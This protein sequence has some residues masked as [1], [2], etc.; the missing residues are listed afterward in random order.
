[1][2]AVG[3]AALAFLSL[4]QGQQIHR[5]GFEGR[6]TAWI[7]GTA[8]VAFRELVHDVT[9]TTARTGQRS[10]HL[11]VT[12]EQSG[13]IYYYYP[14]SRAP[15]TDDLSIS[16][17]IKADRP[18]IQL[19]ARVV[20]PH[21]RN[22]S[23][24]QEPLT[25][26]IYGE[27]LYQNTG[28]WQHL[29]LR[30]PSKLAAQQQRIMRNELKRDVDF[31]DAHVDRVVLNVCAG[32]G[33][34]EL[35]ID[36]L[37]IGPVV[38]ANSSHLTSQTTGGVKLQAPSDLPRASN[39]TG[40]VEV[41]RGQLLVNRKR[42]FIR[43]IRHTDTPLKA[44][45]DAGFN[46]LWFD[47]SVS[48]ATLDEAINLGFWLVPT[49]P[50]TATD[51]RLITADSMR[52]E[53]AR[54][55]EKD[56]VLFWDLGGGLTDEQA[57]QVAQAGQLVR[58]VDTQRP[59]GGDVWDGF[60]PYSLNLDLV[61]MHRWPL[62][63]GLELPQYR[64]WLNQRRLLARSGAFMWTW[65]QTHLPDWYTALVYQRPASAG[66]DEPI[67]P[68]PE[69]I[70]LLTYVALAA[71]CRG[72]G[73]WSDRF[74]ADTHQGRDRLLTLA[75]LNQE[76]KMIEPL[77]MGALEPTW[78]DTSVG[79]VKAAVFRS[80][81]G[82]L[83]MPMWLG[84]GAQY[85]PGQSANVNLSITVPQVPGTAQAFEISPASVRSLRTYREVGG[86]RITLPEFGLTA[87]IVFTADNGQDG[88]LVHFQN[89]VRQT[90]RIAAQWAIY[91]AEEEVDKVSRVEEQLEKAGHTLPDGQKL[92]ENARIRLVSCNDSWNRGDYREAYAEAGR[93]LRP[94]RILMRAQWEQATNELSAPVASP[95]AVSFYT[96]PRHWEFAQ[97]VKKGRI[98]TNVLPGGD[99][100]ATPSPTA[101]TWLTQETT[102][103][104]V[105][106]LASRVTE[107]PREGRQCMM[108]QIDR[109]DKLALPPAALERTFLAVNSPAV[110]LKPGSLVR[111]SG[112][113]RIP[114]PIAASADGALLYDS[115][116]GEPLAI[117]LTDTIP[118]KQFTLYRWVPASGTI[119]VTLALTG[120]GTVYFDDIRIEPLL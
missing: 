16:I 64:L 34:V 82:V 55:L 4:A 84:R 108:L 22:S 32:P 24:L 46:A 117:R 94:L 70:R 113:I 77:L 41:D 91:L 30:R 71:G 107:S 105:A 74:L 66:F 93:V 49:L 99:F 88:L 5:N 48:P 114:K 119:N 53:I 40:L 110:R 87:T 51:S 50:A 29:Q 118:W 103:D 47:N 95:F 42:F 65:V 96:L 97:A 6:E 28:R 75:M 102:L 25:T 81:A 17:W 45:H 109:K 33:Q 62:M 83:V 20:L 7:K 85:V 13:H 37:E 106:M 43:G 19:L 39:R 73:F 58:S 56:A 8:D 21:E 2:L 18:G 112:W 12:C 14:T 38:E 69:Q 52:R 35:W 27:P 60:K 54:F 86:T 101:E 57:T 23:N 15:I 10:E 63:T 115:S 3:A 68:Q 98:G 59:I 100:E 116:G 111:I 44:L 26:F 79:E 1:M 90:S 89:L 61:G 92:L 104:E 80:K 11:Q 67:G 120:L 78:I 36:D 9:D 72:V 76:I 31:T